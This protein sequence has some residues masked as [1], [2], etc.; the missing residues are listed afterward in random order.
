MHYFS[1]ASIVRWLKSVSLIVLLIL[2]S[3]LTTSLSAKEK[4]K[5]TV[6]AA[7]SLTD[8]LKDLQNDYQQNHPQVEFQPVTASSG[9]LARQIEN[10]AP[11]DIFLSANLKWMNYL[12]EKGLLEAGTQAALLKNQLVLITPKDSEITEITID[13]NMDLE[14]YMHDTLLVTGDANSVPAG[15]YAKEALTYL[16][17]WQT[18]ENKVAFT[19]DVRAALAFIERG[20]SNLGVVY[21]TDAYAS[22]KVRIVGVFPDASHA[23]I[24]Y[25][26]AIIKN[27]QISDVKKE[28]IKNFYDYL[29]SDTAKQLFIAAGFQIP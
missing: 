20:E 23:P 2:F 26:M 3:L 8:V 22:D 17:L 11:A 4:I 15:M 1:P 7:A 18:L 25:P 13:K 27:A 14:K 29:S 16:G 21:Q 24:L 6:Y 9:T 10:G 12:D 19:K 5:I 28:E